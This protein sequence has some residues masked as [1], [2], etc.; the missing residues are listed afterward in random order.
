MAAAHAGLNTDG[1]QFYIVPSGDPPSHL[2]WTSGKD[3]SSKSCHTVYGTV[4]DGLEFIDS[5]SKVQTSSDKPNNDVTIRSIII[6]DD[7]VKDSDEPWYQ[8]W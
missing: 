4:T 6:T 7:G 8:F 1:S 5:I 3:C 2:D